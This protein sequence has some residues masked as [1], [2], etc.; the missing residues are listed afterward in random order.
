[1]LTVFVPAASCVGAAAGD[2]ILYVPDEPP[3]IGE[4]IMLP[5][6]GSKYL[7]LCSGSC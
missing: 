6:A 5:D 3:A 4:G 1:M 7:F 2:P